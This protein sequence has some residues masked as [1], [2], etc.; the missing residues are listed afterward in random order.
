MME[1]EFNEFCVFVMGLLSAVGYILEVNENGHKYYKL[2]MVRNDSKS[3][4]AFV[5]KETGDIFKPATW[6]APARHPRGNIQ[7]PES[8]RDFK[9]TGPPYLN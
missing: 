1:E 5:N 4:W 9:W 3:V 2:I 7:N 8:Y 6:K